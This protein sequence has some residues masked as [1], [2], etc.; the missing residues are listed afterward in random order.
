M[1]LDTAR[2]G[3]C[4]T[5]SGGLN[6]GLV[7]AGFFRGVDDESLHRRLLRFQL[8][9]QLALESLVNGGAIRIDRSSVEKLALL[10]AGRKIP[11]KLQL[12]IEASLYAGLIEYWTV[13][14][15]REH[16]RK[17]VHRSAMRDPFLVEELL[18]VLVDIEITAAGRRMNL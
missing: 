13:E 10:E 3:A 9:A 12:E 4:A 8:Q 15:R 2:V 17:I 11:G 7:F 18:Y 1:S 5:S 6:C 14:N 16:K